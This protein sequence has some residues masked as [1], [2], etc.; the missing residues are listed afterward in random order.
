MPAISSDLVGTKG[1][2]VPYSWD[3]KDAMLYAL[4]VGAR[5]Y[6]DL[7]FLFEGK[8][9]KVLPTFSVIGGM[10]GMGV[11]GQID[12]INPVM[13]LHGSQGIELHR[14]LPPSAKVS[15][16]AGLNT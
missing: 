1:D 16:R 9:P 7:N 6:E 4:G 8:G 3:S 13:I 5:P 14:E 10:R 12:G 11:M 15:N 2:P